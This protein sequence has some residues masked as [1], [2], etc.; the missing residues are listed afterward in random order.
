MI[1]VPQIYPSCFLIDLAL[2][3]EYCPTK[4]DSNEPTY[5]HF[6]DSFV[7]II[8]VSIVTHSCNY[9]VTSLSVFLYLS[10]SQPLSNYLSLSLNH[11]FY[12]S[13]KI[14]FL[15]KLQEIIHAKGTS[16]QSSYSVS[17]DVI[18]EIF[19]AH[20]SDTIL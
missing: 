2:T 4:R 19:L 13:C 20:I 17:R 3:I 12:L 5:K 16:F 1:T 9:A 8:D 6:L 14:F 10:T 18:T 7:I 15:R 11:R